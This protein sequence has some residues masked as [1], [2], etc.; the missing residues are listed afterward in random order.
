MLRAIIGLVKGLIV[1]GGI[2][3]GLVALNLT[4]GLWAYLA[5]ALVGALVGVVC[6]RPPWKSETI[7][8]PIVKMIV[9][10]GIGAG[11]CAL[12]RHFLPDMHLATVGPVDLSTRGPTF[13][14]GAI[15]VLYG[16]FVE[17]DDGG[18]SDKEAVAKDKPVDKK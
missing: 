6:G 9:G 18:K 2:G 4:G 12:G 7:W 11:L 5:A 3:Y 16:V 15:G 17:I 14:A 8:T 1:G 10:A 13:L